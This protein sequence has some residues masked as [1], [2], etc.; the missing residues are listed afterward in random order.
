MWKITF[1]TQALLMVLLT[2]ML[3][4]VGPLS[5][6][7]LASDPP[8]LD[9]KDPR[10]GELDF[11][12][13]M[14]MNGKSFIPDPEFRCRVDVI[15]GEYALGTDMWSSDTDGDGMDD[16]WEVC[17]GLDPLDPSDAYEDYDAFSGIDSITGEDLGYG[18]QDPIRNT[19]NGTRNNLQE[20]VNNTDPWDPDTDDDGILDPCDGNSPYP[21]PEPMESNDPIL[22]QQQDVSG[23]RFR[24]DEDLEERADQHY[25]RLT[26]FDAYDGNLWYPDSWNRSRYLE[27]S[28][29]D[30]E[31]TSNITVTKLE[32]HVEWTGGSMA[33]LPTSLAIGYNNYRNQP[34]D[35][36]SGFIPTPLHTVQIK[37]VQPTMDFTPDIHGNPLELIYLDDMGG[38][39]F[40][41][42]QGASSY[43]VTFNDYE[44]D[45]A[46]LESATVPDPQEV[47]NYLSLPPTISQEVRD[48]AALAVGTKTTPYAMVNSIITWL[49]SSEAPASQNGRI[50]TESDKEL[51]QF[52]FDTGYGNSVD[53][54]T[55]FLVFARLYDIPC[56]YVI[57]WNHSGD[58]QDH[59]ILRKDVYAWAEVYFNDLGWV[60]F[61]PTPLYDP[62]P[63]PK[64]CDGD[65]IED[66]DDPDDDNDNIPNA[67]DNC[68]C[69]HDNDGIKIKD[70]QDRDND[71]L[72]N[73]EDVVPDGATMEWEKWDHDNDGLNDTYD[74]DWDYDGIPNDV[75]PFI[76]DHDNDGVNDDD[77]YDDD[78]DGMGD[79]EEIAEGYLSVDHDNDR[80]ADSKDYDDDWDGIPDII[81]RPQGAVIHGSYIVAAASESGLLVYDISN[82]DSPVI[83]GGNSTPPLIHGLSVR[84]YG[85]GDYAF[86][87]MDN[88][89]LGIFDLNNLSN[90]VLVATLNNV[91]RAIDVQLVGTTVYVVDLLGGIVVVDVAD[92]LSPQTLGSYHNGSQAI[93]VEV[94]DSTAYLLQQDPPVLRL[95]N[96]SDPSDIVDISSTQLGFT[97]QGKH[98]LDLIVD[99]TLDRVYVLDQ[100]KGLIVVNISQPDFP[101]MQDGASLGN[102]THSLILGNGVLYA[103]DTWAG[104]YFINTMGSNIGVLNKSD[105]MIGAYDML[106]VGNKSYILM[107]D[108]NMAVHTIN[109]VDTLIPGLV[110][111]SYQDYYPWEHDQDNDMN[112]DQTEFITVIA[113]LAL[114]PDI[115][116]KD[117]DYLVQGILLNDMGIGMGYFP[118]KI[119]LNRTFEEWSLGEGFTALDGSFELPCTPPTYI[120]V[121]LAK[122]L[123]RSPEFGMFKAIDS[124]MQNTSINSS[125]ILSSR[126][127]SEVI[128]TQNLLISGELRDFGGIRL[129][130]MPIQIYWDDGLISTN[131]TSELGTFSYLY[132]VDST[133]GIHILRMD[134]KED[135]YLEG[136]TTSVEITVKH[137]VHL[138][139]GINTS[140]SYSGKN[141]TL[142]GTIKDEYGQ[143]LNLSDPGIQELDL[144]MKG[145]LQGSYPILE[146]SKFNFNLTIPSSAPVGE[147]ELMIK[148]LDSEYY[149]ANQK[150]T[151]L[152]VRRS[153]NI[154]IYEKDIVRVD[155]YN[156]VLEGLLHDS[157]MVPLTDQRIDIWKE[158]DGNNTFQGFTMTGTDGQFTYFV[159][160]PTTQALG[161]M[162]FTVTFNG[163][164]LFD[165]TYS[166]GQ[167]NVL[168]TTFIDAI[169]TDAYRNRS[170]E[171]TGNLRVENG[172]PVADQF[173]DMYW[174]GIF[175]QRARTQDDGEFVISFFLR[176]DEELGTFMAILRYNGSDIYLSSNLSLPIV[177]RS[178]TYIIMEDIF[179]EYLR[180]STTPVRIEGTLFDDLGV[181][182]MGN[183]VL[184][185]LD[186]VMLGRTT[187]ELDGS[188][189]LGYLVPWGERIGSRQLQAR[190]SGARDFISCTGYTNLSIVASTWFQVNVGSELI[191][192][193]ELIIEGK[194]LQDN[195]DPVHNGSIKIELFGRLLSKV[196]TGPDGSF[197]YL[198]IIPLNYP[199]GS[200][201]LRFTYSGHEA[202]YL[203]PADILNIPTTVVAKTFFSI[204]APNTLGANEEFYG[205]VKLLNDR[206]EPMTSALIVVD[207]NGYSRT[208]LTDINGEVRFNGTFGSDHNGELR[209]LVEY[210][211]QDFIMPSQ[212]EWVIDGMVPVTPE[213]QLPWMQIISICV[214]L[215]ILSIA[216]ILAYRYFAKEELDLPDG[217]TSGEIYEIT[218]KNKFAKGVFDS[219]RRTITI[220]KRKGIKR[221][222][223]TTVREYEYV[224]KD[225]HPLLGKKEISRLSRVFEEARYSTHTIQKEH[226]VQ[227]K[228]DYRQIRRNV[229][230]LTEGVDDLD[231]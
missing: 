121:G 77:E 36:G 117:N 204:D 226:M 134:F 169:A 149:M 128:N 136:N 37:D 8:P 108:S 89:G 51:V 17:K 43:T 87:A 45:V 159:Y 56:R 73:L 99:S 23:V 22:V 55:T 189:K 170:I 158:E 1:P 173:I 39:F 103:L 218:A 120:D 115:M 223:A 180:N 137:S 71:G 9:P 10:D 145:Q 167:L 192:N 95:L 171:L 6:L 83:V 110:L 221:A 202:A 13:D 124:A 122:I 176:P 59:V 199:V 25:W 210:L 98:P 64:D 195:G 225:K 219:Y 220:L 82:P 90:P 96:V 24:V 157:G 54:T 53:F 68:R 214:G 52:F 206:N 182:L 150:T 11:D 205:T 100:L 154:V 213:A 69:D 58:A 19:C 207:L 33:F 177:I 188:F 131:V 147:Y 80:I 38:F 28:L 164:E 196:N 162:T 229:K 161:P 166:L 142:S 200:G 165:P 101:Q 191:R 78:N 29:V 230:L 123:A 172:T 44:Y 194:L 209:I 16:F 227:A 148:F 94:V 104:V 144:L 118:V 127:I 129:A 61:D 62:P 92:P 91:G 112:A 151:Q 109:S 5:I 125:V 163:S 107:Q 88:F 18:E 70:D 93:T 34:I 21:W 111:D 67:L 178:H 197:S 201:S 66:D 208:L 85:W 60:S 97:S 135:S 228:S 130:N 14:L 84:S 30:T 48:K 86:G 181:A 179:G 49:N 139:L 42:T 190:F 203:L 184:I 32:Y 198:G 102:H 74:D 231:I 193:D 185:Y 2:L 215:I 15:L 174:K 132:M 146:N 31:V 160:V 217:M 113:S 106:V 40:N 20:Y 26:A 187:T 79:P 105:S 114:A 35:N 143:T 4:L 126:T 47:K 222:Q 211:G 76:H 141:V 140:V 175:V 216:G 63:P 41:S 50:M 3:L 72:N 168:G 65:G 155:D 119:M 152:T 46:L 183:E 116:Y 133:P 186:Q 27:G 224:L 57:G 75:D 138:Y 212:I 156:L 153:T 12:E 81:D 7:S